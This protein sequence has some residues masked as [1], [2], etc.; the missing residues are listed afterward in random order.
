MHESHSD[1]P[2]KKEGEGRKRK[3]LLKECQLTDVDKELENHHFSNINVI[4]GADR[5]HQL[6]PLGNRMCQCTNS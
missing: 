6:M 5:D 2:H 4:T 3:F 1:A